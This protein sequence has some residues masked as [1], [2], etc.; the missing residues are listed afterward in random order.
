MEDQQNNQAEEPVAQ[1]EPATPESQDP[2]AISKAQADEYL[3]GWK[4]AMADYANL[5]KEAERGQGELAKYASG[6]MVTEL[7]P[8]IDSFSKA[9]AQKPQFGDGVQVDPAKLVQWIDGV[10][11]ISDQL[12]NVLSR[13][14][15]TAIDKAGIPFDPAVHEAMMNAPADK[16]HPSGT[17]TKVLESG[18]KLHDRVLRAAKVIVAE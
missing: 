9:M 12:A 3:A 13:A 4:R 2:L 10:G 17:V 1:A 18:Y 8:V 15:V 7:L 6:N 5:K 14:G 11:H 16:D